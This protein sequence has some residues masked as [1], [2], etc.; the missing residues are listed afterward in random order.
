[1]SGESLREMMLFT[2]SSVTWVF[3]GGNS[4][5]GVFQPSSNASRSTF[6]K[7]PSGLMP[8]PRPLRGSAC[9]PESVFMPVSQYDRR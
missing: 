5:S 4:S 1:M 8:A 7:R 3:S 9:F 2:R 6:S